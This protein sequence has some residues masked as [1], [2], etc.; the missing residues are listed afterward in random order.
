LSKIAVVN[1]KK[2]SGGSWS[3]MAVVNAYAFHD[4]ELLRRQIKDISPNLIVACG[5]MDQI[6][7][8]L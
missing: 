3:D 6:I 5:T 1:L 2:A 8:L 4:R 7:W